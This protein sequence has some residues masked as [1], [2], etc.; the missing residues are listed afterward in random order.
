M[1]NIEVIVETPWQYYLPILVRET[2]GT[3]YAQTGEGLSSSSCLV[4]RLIMY[5]YFVAR[6]NSLAFCSHSSVKQRVLNSLDFQKAEHKN[7]HRLE[8]RALSPGLHFLN[9]LI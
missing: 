2:Q 6:T 1:I 9:I 7:L 5:S 3:G 4:S 8:R